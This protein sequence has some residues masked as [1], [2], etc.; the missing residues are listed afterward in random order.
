MVAIGT[1]EAQKILAA[2]I[3]A[4]IAE[5]DLLTAIGRPLLSV[6]SN[7]DAR[8]CWQM[9]RTAEDQQR[10]AKNLA[11]E[12]QVEYIIELLARRV[13]EGEGGGFLGVRHLYA[14]DDTIDI[15]AVRALTKGTASQVITSLTGA[16]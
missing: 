11:T 9:I 1:V 7:G 5:D 14:T 2:A 16:Y 10:R 4:G 8:T 13:R 15:A 12:R 3:K 6:A